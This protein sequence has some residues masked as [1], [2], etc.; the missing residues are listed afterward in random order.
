MKIY[1][2]ICGVGALIAVGFI[3]TAQTKAA[4]FQG[5]FRKAEATPTVKIARASTCSL[6]KGTWYHNGKGIP[7]DQYGDRIRVNMSAFRRPTAT[8]RMLSPTQ[9]EV[10]FPDDA[11]F[12]GTLDGRGKI[13]WNN[14][15]TWQATRFAGSWQYEGK[16]GPRITQ[17][18]DNLSVDMSRYSRP[19]A[20]GNVTTPSTASIQFPDDAT[21]TATLVSPSCVQWSNGTTW[22]K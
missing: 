18:G 20:T 16:W 21:H 4:D 14:N 8:G 9:I 17:L 2:A 1:Q 13:N 19:T 15:T 22:T 11:T 12:I 6:I 10:K 3:S 7:V 5:R